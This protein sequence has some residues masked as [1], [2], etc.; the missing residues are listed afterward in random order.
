MLT[1]FTELQAEF[2]KI[3]EKD[4]S[5]A[6]STD[7]SKHVIGGGKELAINADQYKAIVEKIKAIRNSYTL[8]K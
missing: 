8:T 2:N 6:A 5:A 4:A 3:G 7:K 1:Q